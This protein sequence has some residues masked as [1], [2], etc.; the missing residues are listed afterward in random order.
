MESVATSI[1]KGVTAAL[2][3]GYVTGDLTTAGQKAVGTEE[4]GDAV[5]RAIQAQ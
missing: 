5:V 1:E 3:G 4:F 2:E